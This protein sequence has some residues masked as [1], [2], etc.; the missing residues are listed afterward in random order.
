MAR[1]RAPRSAIL[2]VVVL[3]W[4]LAPGAAAE[5]PVPAERVAPEV[6]WDGPQFLGA[7]A[8]GRVFLL[9]GQGWRVYQIHG[10]DELREKEVL[11]PLPDMG[12]P[13][14]ALGA[15][16]SPSGDSW[17]VQGFGGA[18]RVRLFRDGKEVALPSLDWRVASVGW[19]GGTPVVAVVPLRGGT[20]LDRKEDQEVPV[21]LELARHTWRPVLRELVEL[22]G[23]VHPVEYLLESRD[24]LVTGAGVED[25]SVW[26]APRNAYRLRKISPAGAIRTEIVVGD[27]EV[28][29]RDPTELEQS[30]TAEIL[31]AMGKG[32]SSA[33]RTT[34]ARP[35][36]R[37]VIDAMSMG[38]DGRL[39][40][41]RRPKGSDAGG[42]LDR[43][44][45]VRGVL[46]RVEVAIP[47]YSGRRT[48]VGGQDGLYIADYQATAGRWRI[49]WTR[50]EAASW[51]PV[52]DAH[53]R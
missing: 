7:D 34:R 12:P 2:A 27:G 43:Y 9:D 23:E 46:E 3:G 45:P 39:Y 15:A 38:R 42:Q 8:Q 35:M 30:R 16:L 50:L 37:Q 26:I 48:M 28:E 52:A 10:T 33:P 24:F 51:E 17:L 6:T 41:L 49:P 53:I 1:D 47:P 32:Q 40:I 18:S 13:R 22:P 4:A 19:S 25:S 5:S 21:L 29:Y 11:K 14:Y 44:D 31:A 36:A 20:P